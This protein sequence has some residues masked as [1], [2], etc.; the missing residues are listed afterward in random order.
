MGKGAEAGMKLKRAGMLTKLLLLILLVATVT[1]FLNLRTQ[2]GDLTDQRAALER[3]NARQR[4]E[5]EAL[6]AAI[7]QKDDPE[8]IADVARERLGYVA[9]GEIIFYDSGN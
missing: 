7:E 2:V 1:S 3:Q 5:N 8:R 6:A 4:Q 9:P